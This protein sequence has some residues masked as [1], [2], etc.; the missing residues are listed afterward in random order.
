MITCHHV[1]NVW[2]KT[3]L[4][5]PVWPSDATRS[6]TSG[7]QWFWGNGSRT[8]GQPPSPRRRKKLRDWSRPLYLGESGPG[9]L[10]GPLWVLGENRAPASHLR[11]PRRPPPL[12][13]GC[14][15]L[16]E[17]SSTGLMGL[18]S[19]EAAKQPVSHG[20][21]GEKVSSK[22]PLGQVQRDALRAARAGL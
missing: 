6:D 21:L 20:H 22:M 13:S 3:A 18:L 19:T 8:Q 4:L 10:Q 7:S 9:D 2:P 12:N 15:F 5:L 1:F 11:C 17:A 16:W 14:L